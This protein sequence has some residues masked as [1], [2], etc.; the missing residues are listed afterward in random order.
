MVTGTCYVVA[1]RLKATL[2][3]HEVIG[4]WPAKES[5]L[6]WAAF[7][8]YLLVALRHQANLVGGT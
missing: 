3:I 5:R 2:R 7:L 8:S 1:R 6:T 4:Y